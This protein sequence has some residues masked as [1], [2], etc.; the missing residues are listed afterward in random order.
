LLRGDLVRAR[1]GVGGDGVGEGVEGRGERWS[2]V[3]TLVGGGGDV[4]QS[5]R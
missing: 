5:R 2:T 4:I 3:G 1:A